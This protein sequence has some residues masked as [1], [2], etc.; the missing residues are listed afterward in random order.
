MTRCTDNDRS[1]GRFIVFRKTNWKT[2]AIYL[3]SGGEDEDAKSGEG[4]YNLFYLW[5][6]GWVIRVTLPRIIQPF[7]I[8]H[9]PESWDEATV[10]RLGRNWYYE[11]HAREFGFRF[12]DDMLTLYFGAQ[13]HDSSTTQD[14]SWRIPWKVWRH[15]RFSLYDLKGD[16]FWTQFERQKKGLGFA[17]FEQQRKKEDECPKAKFEFEDYDGKRITVTTHIEER[18]WR[19]GDKWCKW[20]SW[21]KKPLIRRSLDLKFS[22]EVGPEKGSWKG[23]TTGHGIDMLPGELHEEAFRRYCGME[24]NTRREQ[25][26]KI[27]FI[28][29]L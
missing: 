1:V 27:R 13:T 28:G 17:S 25:K 7:R 2:F 21:F 14:W 19:W 22:E 10:K 12:T 3:S 15:V 29:K 9:F 8:K 26:F 23:G 18:E 4:R 16:H 20:L 24:W 6:F 5:V 11:I